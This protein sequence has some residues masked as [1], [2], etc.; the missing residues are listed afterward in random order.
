MLI[1]IHESI[2]LVLR[3]EK[4]QK[5]VVQRLLLIRNAQ[6]NVRE[7][8]LQYLYIFYSSLHIILIINRNLYGRVFHHRRSV[9]S[10]NRS[11]NLSP[12]RNFLRNLLYLSSNLFL[13]RNPLR[14]LLYLSLNPVFFLRINGN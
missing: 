3:V 5:N 9:L 12:F 10:A 4:N 13:L 2:Q 11:S 6:Y 7:L 8:I 1:S 14:N